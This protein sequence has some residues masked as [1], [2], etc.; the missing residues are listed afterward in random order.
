MLLDGSTS[1][2]P[3]GKISEWL[4]TK[5]SGPASFV[6]ESATAA[7]T[8]VKSLTQGVY[9]FELKVTDDKGLFAK[10]TVQ[11][12]V[13]DPSQPN[14]LPFACAGAD[15]T[16]TLPTNTVTLNGSCSSD[17]D[18][19]I[20]SYLWAKISGPSTFNISNATAVQTQVANLAQGSY[21]FELKVTDAGGLSSK[22]TVQ[23]NVLAVASVTC[24]GLN[25]PIVTAQLI[26]VGNLSIPRIAIATV[27]AGNKIFFAG[28]ANDTTVLS[29]V[30]IYDMSSQSWS[31]AEL[32]I[33]REVGG[34]VACGNKVLFAGGVNGAGVPFTRID[35][36][37]LSTQSWSTAELPFVPTF[38]YYFVA[39]AV[40]NK[41]L[42][43]YPV[44]NGT[45]VM[46]TQVGIY[47]VSTQGWTTAILSEPRAAFSTV[48]VGD[49]VYF[50]GGYHRDNGPASK[51]ID[52][53]DNNTGSWSTSLLAQP[54]AF[55]CSIYKDGKIYWAGGATYVDIMSS[56][57]LTKTCSVEIKDIN[58]QAS[59][60]SSLYQ[61]PPF[62]W[63]FA[64][65]TGGRLIF[66][67]GNDFRSGN[68]MKF[69]IYDV[70]PDSWKIGV[71]S[72]MPSYF[73]GSSYVEA[74]N[75]VFIAGGADACPQRSSCQYHS[76]VYKLQF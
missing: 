6:I 68:A 30:D 42:F 4:W 2:A 75:A 64:F 37:D 23:I 19:N 11:V 3:N 26:P 14:R 43:A 38:P 25:R 34:A 8:L 59:N 61:P 58:T 46:S 35:I 29:R 50:S 32:S 31:T 22:D 16:V 10:D 53:Y 45:E 7:K 57:Y 9:Q 1:S 24:G 47:N 15:Q 40:G 28:G 73:L 5:V 76:Q 27:T 36:Y 52:I 21:Q 17:P 62:D 66:L 39:A 18:N 48:T 70:S 56:D 71:V 20:T 55:H 67:H 41:A 74:N 13:N 72:Q 60:F 44:F 33:P 69:D 63:S 54:K 51:T 49:K 12:L 65:D